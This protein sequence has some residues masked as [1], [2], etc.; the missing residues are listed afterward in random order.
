MADQTRFSEPITKDEATKIVATMRDATNVWIQ[1]GSADKVVSVVF[2]ALNIETMVDVGV[3]PVIVMALEEWTDRIAIYF[4]ARAVINLSFSERTPFSED[5]KV[6]F[7]ELLVSHIIAD[8]TVDDDTSTDQTLMSAL[9]FLTR[10][11]PIARQRLRD[12]PTF[13]QKMDA[14]ERI[15]P[16]LSFSKFMEDMRSL[17]PSGAK[18][19]AARA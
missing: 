10:G 11:D 15:L 19:K 17:S 4:V 2:H 9:S 7:I 1:R 5:M 14:L 8:L 16:P 18:T 6:Q 13:M 12:I 3:L